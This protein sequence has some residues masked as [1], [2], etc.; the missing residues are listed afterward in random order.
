[1][2]W[3]DKDLKGI[4]TTM[5]ERPPWE[6]DVP[7][8][9]LARAAF[10]KLVVSG[11][12]QKAPALAQAFGGAALNAICDALAHGPVAERAVYPEAAHGAHHTSSV[13]FNERLRRVLEAGEK[14]LEGDRLKPAF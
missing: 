12:R 13:E 8:E 11:G 10:P 9:T 6:A 7:L 14:L 1:M 3:S 5:T 4:R 2:A